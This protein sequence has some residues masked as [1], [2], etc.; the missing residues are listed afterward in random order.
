MITEN[1]DE[2]IMKCTIRYLFV[3]L[4]Q[5]KEDEDEGFEYI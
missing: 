3:H 4:G 2:S 1:E 5:S